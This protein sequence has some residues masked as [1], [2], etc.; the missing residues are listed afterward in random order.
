[1]IL[2][3]VTYTCTIITITIISPLTDETEVLL[4]A[5]L[6]TQP[7]P[8]SLAWSCLSIPWCC[9]SNDYVVALTNARNRSCHPC[10][11]GCIGYSAESRGQTI[12]ASITCL[13][14]ARR[15]SMGPTRLST[16]HHTYSF[17]MCSNTR[18]KTA[19]S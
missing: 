15:G 13:W 8:R 1:M 16:L 18:S 14:H 10:L 9:P 3:R 2:N 12:S 6:S 7:S 5:R 11:V 19:S 17:V 4:H